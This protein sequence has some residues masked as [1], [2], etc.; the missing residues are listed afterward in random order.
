MNKWDKNR[1]FVS[2]GAGV[3]GTSLV[4]ELLTRGAEVFVGDLKPRPD[5]FSGVSRY[6]E[7]D[8]ITL[9][10]RELLAFQPEVYFHLAATFERSTET[11]DFF[12]DNFHNNIALSHHLLFLFKDL[13]SLKKIIFASSY[14]IYDPSL[15]LFSTPQTQLVSLKETSPVMPR[16]IC[17]MAKFLHEQELFFVK[18]F[19]PELQ[20]VNARIF[21]SYGKNS[22][23][24]IS[25]WIRSLL[26]RE[27]IVVYR[28]E[29][30]FDYIYAEDVAKGLMHL[31][32]ASFSGVVNLGTG[33]AR[34]VSEILNVLK[35]HFGE[36][37][38][39]MENVDIPYEASQADMSL[40]HQLS[41]F[42]FRPLEETVREIISFEEGRV[43]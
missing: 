21:R 36:F 41:D 13:P 12:E 28:P 40:F 34:S 43:V 3:I 17:G 11:Y 7:G 26:N 25:R 19:R 23:D 16:N 37:N 39:R 24:I 22:R 5:G 29:G 35:D 8:L 42:R 38:C 20:V 2:G 18:K 31:A 32:E 4:S 9:D 1:V 27:E 33:R 10:A 14:L 30:Q 15:Y 6:R